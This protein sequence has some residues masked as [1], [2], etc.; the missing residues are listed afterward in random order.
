M[1]IV[2]GDLAIDPHPTEFFLH[3]KTKKNLLKDKMIYICDSCTLETHDT[4][5]HIRDPLPFGILDFES[6][7]TVQDILDNMEKPR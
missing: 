4:V 6:Q 7:L 2:I 5:Y 1:N 3:K